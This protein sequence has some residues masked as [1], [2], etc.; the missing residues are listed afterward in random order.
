MDQRSIRVFV[1][2]TFRD[3]QAEREELVKRIF[4][5]LR[6]LCESQYVSWTDVDLRWGITDEEKAEGKVLPICLEEI[7]RCRPYFIGILGERY[8][9]VPDSIPQ[10]LIEQELWLKEHLEKSVTE[11]EIIHGVLKDPKMADHAFFYFR[12]PAYI[13]SLPKNLQKEF[14]ESEEGKKQKLLELKK[15][16]RDSGLPVRENYSNPQEL[17]QLV[18]KDMTDVINKLFPEVEIDPLDRLAMEHEAFA[19]SRTRV[20]IGRQEYF[21]KLDAH[22]KSD[23][24]PLVVIGES[25][26]GKSALLANWALKYRENHPNDL[27]IMHFIGSSP[28]STNWRAMLRR[29]MGELSRKLEIEMEIPDKPDELRL[30]FAN[31]LNMASVKGRL[32]LIIDALNQLE[33][34]DGAPDLVWLPPVIPKNVRMILSSLPGR[35]LNELNK[36]GWETL[37]IKPLD[38]DERK[39]LITKYLKQ[40]TKSLNKDRIRQIASAEQTANPLFLR[41]LL[42][43]LRVF[44]SHE[45]LDER[46]SYYLSAKDIPDLYERILS[47][48]EEDYERDRKGLVKDAMSLIWAS[49]RGLSEVELMDLLGKDG[50]PLQRAYWS[51]LYLAS[52]QSLV[53][54]SGLIGFF[55][56]YLRSA[57]ERKYLK[58]EDDKRKEHSLLAD[59]FAKQKLNARRIDE[60]P[61]QLAQAK[62]WKRLY[63]LLSDLPFFNSA[64]EADEFEVKAYWSQIENNSSF[65]KV[66]AYKMVIGSPEKYLNYVESIAKLFYET[67]NMEQASSL[68]KS[69]IE[70]YLK[71]GNKQGLSASLGNQA[72]ILHLQG[73][74]DG[75][76]ALHKEEEMLCR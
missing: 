15:K 41:A 17:G 2:S 73:D 67:G 36:R 51:P 29:I 12:D 4:P 13:N 11:L 65:H 6:K 68:G 20:Y 71:T 48:Y 52:D 63:D 45:R 46:I 1:S 21:D 28:Y 10:E 9:W 34:R 44:G 16:I 58:T 55:H 59:Y 60:Q 5:Q 35:P 66:E 30:A 62:E 42:D 54:R 32:V 53:S 64:W 33:D 18:L 26:S 19:Q 56:D 14:Q 75:A 37:E 25:G 70:Y 31:F 7:K 8:G 61:W 24:Q 38:D 69:Q 40:Y 39:E 27:V 43:E 23:S 72:N 76:M 49:R 22:V 3:M 47:R 74:L 57:V 50:E